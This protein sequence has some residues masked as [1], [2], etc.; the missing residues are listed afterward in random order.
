MITPMITLDAQQLLHAQIRQ[1][2][3]LPVAISETFHDLST[4]RIQT[5]LD[6]VRFVPASLLLALKALSNFVSLIND[7]YITIL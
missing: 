6:Y 3:Y 1:F 5:W 2:V 4:C 7:Q